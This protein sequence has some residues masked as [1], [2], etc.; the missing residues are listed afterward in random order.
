[1]VC[2]CARLTTSFLDFVIPQLRFSLQSVARE[3]SILHKLT[4]NAL[5]GILADFSTVA[6][7]VLLV[8]AVALHGEGGGHGRL[9]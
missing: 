6:V 9:G 3:R 5:E 7:V 2:V 8:V 1:M 4:G